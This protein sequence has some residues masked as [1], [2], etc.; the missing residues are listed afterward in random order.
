VPYDRNQANT[1]ALTFWTI[2]CKD[3]LLGAADG[4]PSIEYYRKQRDAPAKD[5]EALFVRDKDG[6]ESGVFRKVD[7]AAAVGRQG[8][9]PDDKI[10]HGPHGLDDCAHYLSQ[11]VRAGGARI[12]TQWGVHGLVDGL[13][14]LPETKV[15]MERGDAVAGQRIID[16][17]IFKPGDM[18][19]Y[20]HNTKTKEHSIGYGHSAMYVGK[21]GITCH[22]TCRFKDQGDSSDDEWSLDIRDFTYTFIHFSSD[23]KVVPGTAKALTGWWKAEYGG[24]E[25][26]YFVLGE[27]VA[28]RSQKAPRKATDHLS[29]HLSAKDTAYWFQED[30]DAITFTWKDGSSLEQWTINGAGSVVKAMSNDMAGKATKLF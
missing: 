21:N 5:W 1:Y 6:T 13:Q 20:F 18:I 10:F 9:L 22:S 25:S 27:G 23:D 7:V 17:G 26:Y 12:D 11:C 3:G 14:R 15:L 4:H 19:G 8:L 29:G 24:R 16:S 30:H 28:R 2:P